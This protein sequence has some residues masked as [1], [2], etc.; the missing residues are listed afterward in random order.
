MFTWLF[1]INGYLISLQLFFDLFK[2]ISQYF[3]FFFLIIFINFYIF[4]KKWHLKYCL[5][6]I[7]KLILIL[8][9]F[10]YFR[11]KLFM[12][13]V[14]MLNQI[15]S[16]LRTIYVI[17]TGI[18]LFS[19]FINIY[20]IRLIIM[21]LYLFFLIFMSLGLSYEFSFSTALI[22]HHNCQVGYGFKLLNNF[23]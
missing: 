17:F 5:A 7:H 6:L 4:N 14:K 20:I 23:L 15:F 1:N 18:I 21:S 12:I 11:K 8:P 3:D 13:L 10:K 22:N 19:I 2:F 16:H 9:A